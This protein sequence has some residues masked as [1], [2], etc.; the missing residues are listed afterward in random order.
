MS[1]FGRRPPVDSDAP[2]VAELV[3]AYEGS[4][5]G[6]TAYSLADLEAEWESLEL[7]RDALV[8][9]DGERIVGYGSLDDRGELWRSE[10]F[11]HPSERGRGLGTQLV[12]ALEAAAASCGAR[13][14]QNNVAEPD[15]PGHRLLAG[16]DYRPV[17]VFRELR[18]ELDA[19]P[20]PPEW[21][22]GLAPEEFEAGRDAV[23]F[24][25]AEQ[26]AFADQWEFRPRDLARWR[27][28]HLE[29]AGFDPSLWRV[30]RAGEEVV[31]GAICEGN[32][33]GGG[34]IAVLFTRRPWRG[35]GIARALLRDAFGKFW[36]RGEASVG[37]SVD[38]DNATGAFQLYESVG[39]RPVLG[40][41][42]HEKE[43]G[44]YPT[45]EG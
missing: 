26:E 44:S 6:T 17:R 32:R 38:A 40:W 11:V 43:L 15:G 20:E 33:Y 45:Y 18:I 23:A 28:L 8:L 12:A 4:L 9:L 1:S 22:E 39:M 3:I 13:R 7:E 2:F 16:L 10:G 35:R 30:V 19:A 5:Y 25:A 31:A 36:D 34:W 27:E 24:H 42:L 14:I 21:P 29:S 37:L 41:V